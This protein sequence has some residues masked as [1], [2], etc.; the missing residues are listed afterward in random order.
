[1]AESVVKWRRAGESGVEPEVPRIGEL[2]VRRIG[3]LEVR[4]IGE[5][6]GGRDGE[7]RRVDGARAK[8]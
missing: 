8:S 4:R 7:N 2:E 6:E 3:E 1:M 5:L